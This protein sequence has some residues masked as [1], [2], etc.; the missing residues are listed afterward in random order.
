MNGIETNET[1]EV[2]SENQMSLDEN[3]KSMTM[4][5]MRHSAGTSIDNGQELHNFRQRKE[6]LLNN[7]QL[8]Q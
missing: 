8:L 2:L 3:S 4:W 5:K 6:I 7:I 1:K